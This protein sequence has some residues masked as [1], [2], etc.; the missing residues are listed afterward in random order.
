MAL[1]LPMTYVRYTHPSEW[2]SEITTRKDELER[3]TGHCLLIVACDDRSFM[4]HQG[5]MHDFQAG[6]FSIEALVV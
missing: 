1:S 4:T 3:A 2:C 5:C 6:D